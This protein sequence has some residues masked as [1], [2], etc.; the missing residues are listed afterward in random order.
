MYAPTTTSE[1][2]R[3]AY[4]LLQHLCAPVPMHARRKVGIVYPTDLASLQ[5][6]VAIARAQLGV[7]VLIGPRE[8]IEA[9][10][11]TSSLELA[12]IEIE[13]T[14][15]DPRIAAT[16]ACTLAKEK[17]V[18][19]LMKGGLHT[20]ELMH[21]VLE[22]DGGLRTRQ[23]VSHTFA[24]ELP[25]SD[26]LL[27]LSDCAVNIQP[28]LA[29]K[30]SIIENAMTV[31]RAAGVAEPRIGILS[32]T[33]SVLPG[34]QSTLDAAALRTM[35]ARGQ[36]RGARLDGPLALDNAVSPRSAQAKKI[37]SDVA[38]HADV[39]IMPNLEAG[40]ILYKSLIYFG[41]ADCAGIVI[42]ARVPVALTSRA[43][44]LLSR[45]ASVALGLRT[46][47]ITASDG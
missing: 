6:A 39:L 42:G 38:G 41:G 30:R 11:R 35:A 36:I 23:R 25:G 34:M 37:I 29:T 22:R 10:A 18:D 31:A 43:E 28:D 27:L 21:A 19:I 40:N 15:D 3:D 5:A 13:D 24:I 47:G 9:L 46:L 12:A 32:A 20:D 44:S 2:R 7:P 4:P 1:L 14:A 17:R 8:P 16:H 26:A 33:E 45:V